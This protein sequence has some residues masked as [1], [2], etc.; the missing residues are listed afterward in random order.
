MGMKIRVLGW[1]THKFFSK[2]SKWNVFEYIKPYLTHMSSKSFHFVHISPH[3]TQNVVVG[4]AT[5][6]AIFCQELYM[7]LTWRDGR[8]A[9]PLRLDVA[10]QK[11]R[12]KPSDIVLKM[13]TVNYLWVIDGEWKLTSNKCYVFWHLIHIPVYSSSWICSRWFGLFSNYI[14]HHNLGWFFFPDWKA[15]TRK[16]VRYDLLNIETHQSWE[17]NHL[18]IDN[19]VKWGD[20]F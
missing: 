18:K 15:N 9:G 8:N 19:L 2:L 7:L 10:W 17:E 11:Q 4:G 14:N 3:K 12:Q 6:L 13:C 5:F 16:F 20:F 1:W